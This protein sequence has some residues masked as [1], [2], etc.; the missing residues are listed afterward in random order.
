[1]EYVISDY[2]TFWQKYNSFELLSKIQAGEILSDEEKAAYL[3]GENPSKICV[4]GI[5]YDVL[6]L[7]KVA[8]LTSEIDGFY[9]FLY[10]QIN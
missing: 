4:K 8:R 9:H 2:V 6:P 7:S 10:I 3:T 1:M 5:W